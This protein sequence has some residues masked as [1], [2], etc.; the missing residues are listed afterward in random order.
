MRLAAQDIEIVV[1][2]NS[3]DAQLGIDVAKL[4]DH[5]VHYY[6]DPRRLSM[7]ENYESA[8]SRCRGEYVGV[9]G[10]DD[11]VTEF[12]PMVTRWAA[13]ENLDLVVP[14][15]SAHFVWP[16]LKLPGN[17]TPAPGELR[18]NL[19]SGKVS[20]S[21]NTEELLK[22]LSAAGQSFASLPKAYYGIVSRRSLEMVHSKAGKY[23]PGISPDMAAAVALSLVKPH[24]YHIDIPCFLPGS[25]GRS[26]A[27]LSGT[28]RHIGSLRDQPHL[29]KAELDQWNRSIPYFYSVPT[30]WAEACVGAILL[31]GHGDLLR[32]FNFPGLYAQLLSYYPAYRSEILRCYPAAVAASGNAAAMGWFQLSSSL[33]KLALLRAKY[34]I[35]RPFAQ[36]AKR[37]HEAVCGLQDIRSACSA[38]ENEL[39]L[40]KFTPEACTPKSL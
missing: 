33:V 13:Q 23:F 36:G 37:K 39:C 38:L 17:K 25:S 27:G 32:H 24:V 19:P 11:G 30:I 26:N 7:S 10:D 18:F 2:D 4:A 3:D 40:R 29:S 16:D 21:D 5:R 28:N 9:I 6:H 15:N 12:L 1:Q 22:V 35:R 20:K 8:L 14:T 31:M 34:L